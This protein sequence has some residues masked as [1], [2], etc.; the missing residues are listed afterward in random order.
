MR[1]NREDD[2]PRSDTDPPGWHVRERTSTGYPLMG[3]SPAERAESVQRA[4]RIRK[5]SEI[6]GHGFVGDGPYCEAMLSRGPVGDPTTTGVITMF[7]QC[8][9]SAGLHVESDFRGDPR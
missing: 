9:Y 1:P 7:V 2:L 8:G 4:A 5:Q 3:S 6:T